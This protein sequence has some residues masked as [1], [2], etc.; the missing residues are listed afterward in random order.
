MP[1]F[2]NALAGAAGSGGAAAY[3]ISRSLRFNSGDSAYLSRTPSSAGNRK[4][5]TWSGWFKRN[6][7]GTQSFL[8]ASIPANLDNYVQVYTGTDELVINTKESGQA[9]TSTKTQQVFRDPAAWYHLVVAIDTTATGNSGK[10]RLKL[11]INGKL[12]GDSDY[13]ADG[14]ASIALDSELRINSTN[15]HYIGKQGEYSGTYANVYLTEVHFVDG[16]QLTADDFGEYDA[17]TGVWNPKAYSGTYGTNGFHLDF[18]DNSSTTSGSNTGIGKDTSGNGNYF[19]STNISV[20]SGSG[21]DSLIDSPTNYEAASGNNG[22]NYATWNPLDVKTTIALSNGNLDLVGSTDGRTRATLAMPSGKWYWE[23]QVGDVPASNHIG[24]WATNVPISNDTYRVIYRGDGYWIVGGSAAQEWSSVLTGDIVGITFDAS[25]LETKFYKNNSLLGTKT[26]PA[27]PSGSAYT[28]AVILAGSNSSLQANFGQRPFAHTPP[29]GYKSLCTTN[30]DDLL[31]ADGSTAMDVLTYDGTN[32]IG[33]SVTGLSFAPDFVWIKCDSTGTTDHVL[34]N[35]INEGSHLASNTTDQEGTGLIQSLDSG[36]FSLASNSGRTNQ[37]G[38][39]YVGWCWDGGTTNTSI[40]A[41][42]LNSSLFD[43][44]QTWSNQVTGTPYSGYPITR[45]FNN[46]DGQNALPADNN[47][48]VFTPNP[49]FSNASTVKIWYYYPST[50]AN[51]FKING[52]AVGNDVAQTS[53]IQTHTFNVSGFTSLSWSRNKYGTEDTGIARIDVDGVQLVDN[54]VSV[55]N[56]PSI[57]STVRANTSAGF[58]ICTYTGA[59]GN[60]S[61]AHGL[62]AAPKFIAIKNRSNAANWFVMVDIGTTYYK[63]GHFNTT[64]Q[65]ADATSQPVSSTTVTLGNNNAWFGA[66]NDN[67]V[68]YCWAP[69]EGYSKFGSYEAN[70]SSTDGPFV[71]TGFRP[72]WIMVKRTDSAGNWTILDN[73][74]NTYNEAD[75]LL[76]PNLPDSEATTTTNKVDLTSNGF[77]LRGAGGN[78]NASGGTYIYAAFAEHPQKIARAR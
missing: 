69:V 60:Q 45:A 19:D 77:K 34:G 28:P 36:G 64:D 27:L 47:E 16:Q 26:A 43:Q 15:T 48:L 72:A 24:I 66:N 4:T 38:R 46:N 2:N 55:P 6:E 70:G 42:S 33:Y 78:T 18:S 75:K 76:F 59:T 5:W 17:N 67:Y 62:N 37:S 41:G 12:L 13:R 63:Y 68:A 44:S 50:H 35:K 31:I 10:D 58:S 71:Y 49:A 7:L 14:R 73:A 61:F 22:G 30:L 25:T 3:E 53:T 65:L 52:T 57:P 11:Y 23:I 21:N 40:S 51:A 20:A 8:F 54:T 32:D 39:T 1:I 56:V 74:R 29:T 9:Q